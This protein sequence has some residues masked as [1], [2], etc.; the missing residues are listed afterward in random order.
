MENLSLQI[1]DYYVKR[2]EAW[3]NSFANFK[4]L[5]VYVSKEKYE[6]YQSRAKK[7]IIEQQL[8]R[9]RKLYIYETKGIIE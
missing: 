2:N 5:T 6:Q 1:S 9:Q 4:P 7:H 3:M 8:K